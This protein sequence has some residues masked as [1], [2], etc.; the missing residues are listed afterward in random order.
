MKIADAFGG[1]CADRAISTMRAALGYDIGLPDGWPLNSSPG[2]DEIVTALPMAFPGREVKVWC[3][4]K[5]WEAADIDG[6]ILY[7]GTSLQWEKECDTYLFAFTYGR[8]DAGHMVVGF[9]SVYG[10]MELSLAI[11]VRIEEDQ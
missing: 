4:L 11:A 2:V 7:C 6:D 9:P 10:D 8:G 1:R 5:N 3:L